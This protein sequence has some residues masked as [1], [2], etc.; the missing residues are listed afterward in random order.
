M[1][2][3]VY[4]A[5]DPKA[6]KAARKKELRGRDREV[7]DLRFVLK[8]PQGMRVIWNMLCK[9]GAFQSVLHSSGSMVYYNAGKQDLGHWLLSEVQ[10]VDPNK[11][12]EMMIQSK[13]EN[14]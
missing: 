8:S 3:Q 6:V 12:I 9:C 2:A 13:E 4:N 5:A 14:G 10:E 11:L 1:D 7:E